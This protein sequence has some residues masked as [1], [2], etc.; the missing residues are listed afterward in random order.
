[1]TVAILYAAG[2]VI[3]C[4]P[5]KLTKT[6]APMRSVLIAVCD[7]EPPTMPPVFV[8]IIG[9][10]SRHL[11]QGSCLSVEGEPEITVAERD[12]QPVAKVSMLARRVMLSGADGVIHRRA[13]ATEKGQATKAKNAEAHRQRNLGLDGREA[14][15]GAPP[16]QEPPP[17]DDPLDD[18]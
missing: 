1:M 17:F 3:W 13:K 8:T 7:Q 12:G 14:P 6:N 4:G 11:E 2:R 18:L 5:E 16:G 10:E 15:M 9:S